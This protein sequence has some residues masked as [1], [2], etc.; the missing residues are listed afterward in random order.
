VEKAPGSLWHALRRKWATDRKGYPIS[1][2][3]SPTTKI[4]AELSVAPPGL[5]PKAAE[6]NQDSPDPEGPLEHPEFQQLATIYASSCHPMLEFD[7]FRA[8][9]CRTL[10]TQMLDLARL[11][12]VTVPGPSKGPIRGAT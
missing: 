4:V 7:G 10:L 11:T 1:K 3:E 5:E 2:G 12:D 8:V 9:L 6:G